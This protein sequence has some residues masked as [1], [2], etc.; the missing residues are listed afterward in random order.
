MP[1]AII[2]DLAESRKSTLASGLSRLKLTQEIASSSKGVLS[3]FA[4]RN[5]KT[6]HTQEE[7]YQSKKIQPNLTK[8]IPKCDSPQQYRDVY[9]SMRKRHKFEGSDTL[10]KPKVILYPEERIRLEWRRV[11]K[12]GSGLVNMGNTCFVNSTL[13]CLT[14]TAPLVNYC[15]SDEHSNSCKQAGFCMVCE[16]QCHIRRCFAGTGHAIRPQ[17]I[18]QKLR[19]IAKHMQWGHQED[20]H[21]FLRYLID[22]LHKSC[23]NGQAKLDKYSK[24]TTVVSHIFGGFLRSQVKCLRCG[25]RSNTF[26]PF[27]D[28]SLEVKNVATLEKAFE[29]FVQPE[30]LESENA[31]MCSRCKQKVS[32]EKRLSVHKHPNVL[33]I[34]LKRFDY[35]RTTGKITRHI[36]F[37]DKLNIRPYLSQRQ[38]EPVL[39]S[40]NAVLVHSGQ[41]CHSGHYFSY[42]KSPS[43]LWYCMN[44]SMVQQVKPSR[45]FDSEAYLLFYT[46]ISKSRNTFIGPQ[47]PVDHAVNNMH[48]SGHVNHSM[49]NGIRSTDA[50]HPVN[51][52]IT[53]IVSKKPLQEKQSFGS[54]VSAGSPSGDVG[55]PVGK[56]RS[57][58][59]IADGTTLTPNKRLKVLNECAKPRI[60]VHIKNGKVTTFERSRDKLVNGDSKPH[61]PGLVP[62]GDDSDSDHERPNKVNGNNGVPVHRNGDD[63][64][65][66]GTVVFDSKLNATTSVPGNASLLGI[67]EKKIS[68]KFSETYRQSDT[69]VMPSSS[70]SMPNLTWHVKKLGPSTSVGTLSISTTEWHVNKECKPAEM[71]NLPES[72]SAGRLIPLPGEQTVDSNNT[73]SSESTQVDVEVKTPKLKPEERFL[74]RSASD[75]VISMSNTNMTAS[76]SVLSL[77]HSETDELIIKESANKTDVSAGDT[78]VTTS[79]SMLSVGL[80]ETDDL[81]L[82]KSASKTNLSARDTN[83]TTSTSMLSVGLPEVDNTI[84]KESISKTSVMSVRDVT[85]STSMLS[86]ELSQ[87]ILKESASKTDVSADD[88]DV[89]TS[90][91]MVSLGPPGMDD[92]IVD[93]F[94]S[95]ASTVNTDNTNVTTSASMLS[96]EHSETDGVIVN[97]SASKTCTVSTDNTNVTTSASMLSLGLPESNEKILKESASNASMGT[98]LDTNVAYSASMLSLGPSESLMVV[99]SG[100]NINSSCSLMDTTEKR[101]N[102]KSKRELKR[103]K[104]LKKKS[105]HLM[106][107]SDDLIQFIEKQKKKKKKHKHKKDKDHAERKHRH[108]KDDESHDEEMKH[109]VWVEKTKDCELKPVAEHQWDHPSDQHKAVRTMWDGTKSSKVAEELEK[110]TSFKGYGSSVPSWDGGQNYM[111]VDIK[112]DIEK[113]VIKMKR[114]RD[115]SN[116]D[117]DSP[118]VKKVKRTSENHVNHNP[119][120]RNQDDRHKTQK[121]VSAEHINEWKPANHSQSSHFNHARHSSSYLDNRRRDSTNNKRKNSWHSPSS[122]SNRHSSYH[123]AFSHY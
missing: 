118:K 47:V 122:S 74:G 71:T 56:K 69:C 77:G 41:H 114:K 4:F 3:D 2:E 94:V 57:A 81:I 18:L 9:K 61:M 89:T 42:V 59:C 121:S 97:K 66:N 55:C 113:D 50:S 73:T 108:H 106:E 92:V 38:G 25:E 91:S 51:N 100:T 36:E 110:S 37:P 10:P 109:Y 14:Y 58:T 116:N 22:G 33:T 26:D 49:Q 111:D 87:M 98:I 78:N 7:N 43:Q 120:Q 76:A 1:A 48:K 40:L 62:Y 27:M 79:A 53:H 86:L 24:E 32:A 117:I 75:C 84:L 70:K 54:L 80:S 44:D 93:N 12:I 45:V 85:S 96:L 52:N 31:Y 23:L 19:Q 20:A 16:L 67:P 99:N 90:A 115:K 6:K 101:S 82:D 15:F 5:L 65:Q 13:Q 68:L 28:I 11:S 105:K 119:F 30:T 21:E 88:T 102:D 8:G 35:N 29:K 123:G 64:I 104:K 83:V 60:V 63:V 112:K 46:K 17:S 34:Q 72:T 95:K 39:Y 107:Q 103:E